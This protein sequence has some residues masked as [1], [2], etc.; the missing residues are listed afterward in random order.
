VSQT[1]FSGLLDVNNF[2][3]RET[4]TGL[5]KAVIE[6]TFV[7]YGNPLVVKLQALVG[8]GSLVAGVLSSLSLLPISL[9]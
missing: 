1:W 3:I 8:A 7:V 2:Y 9:Q 6:I 4:I 5:L